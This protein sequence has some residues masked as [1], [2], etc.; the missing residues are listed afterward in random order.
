[1]PPLCARKGSDVLFK[2]HHLAPHSEV[3][4]AKPRAAA[5][6]EETPREAGKAQGTP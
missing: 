2:S 1:M 4:A 5:R 6:K 3:E